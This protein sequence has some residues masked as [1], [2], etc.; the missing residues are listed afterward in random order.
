[1][2]GVKEIWERVAR[3]FARRKKA[4]ID[5]ES[6]GR[7]ERTEVGYAIADDFAHTI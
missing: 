7:R 6:I 5:G 2:T 4:L 1:L 3:L